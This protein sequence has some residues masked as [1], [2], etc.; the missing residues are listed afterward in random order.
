MLLEIEILKIYFPPGKKIKEINHLRL[1]EKNR[2][3]L[4]KK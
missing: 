1:R 4:I 2:I 3:T